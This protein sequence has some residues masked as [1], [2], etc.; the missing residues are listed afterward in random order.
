M[1]IPETKAELIDQ[2][3]RLWDEL[4]ETMAALNDDQVTI[5]GPDG[6]SIKDH[7]THLLGWEQSLVA[8]LEG[9]DRLVAMGLPD[10]SIRQALIEAPEFEGIN[11]HLRALHEDRGPR[12]AM[13]LL[14]RANTEVR[15]ALARLTDADLQGPV[16]RVHAGNAGSFK[17]RPLIDLIVDNTC[18]HIS[19]HL[20]LI[21]KLS[22]V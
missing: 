18:N 19:E 6:W 11:E 5:A 20:G 16:S 7:I 1:R 22:A 9:K 14:H 15:A 8:L 17:D 21:R 4:D 3:E 2:V 10:T 13:E 12:E